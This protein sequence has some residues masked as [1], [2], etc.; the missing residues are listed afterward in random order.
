MHFNDVTWGN[1]Q[2]KNNLFYLSRSEAPPFL[3]QAG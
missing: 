2:N 3:Y 1:F